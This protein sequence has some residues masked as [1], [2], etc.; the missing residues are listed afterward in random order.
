MCSQGDIM[1]LLWASDSSGKLLK[2]VDTQSGLC[3]CVINKQKK[4]K[5]IHR[6]GRRRNVQIDGL[7][8]KQNLFEK[9]NPATIS[10][11]QFPNYSIPEESR[12]STSFSFPHLLFLYTC[13]WLLFL[14]IS[15]KIYT[16]NITVE[17]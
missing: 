3:L 13:F 16:G 7:A 8:S 14:S 17:K 10:S 5:K 12:R 15:S 2:M 1:I 9:K 11:Y 6:K 4:K